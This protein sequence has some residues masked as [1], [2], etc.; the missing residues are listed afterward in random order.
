MTKR[1]MLFAISLI[2]VATTVSAKTLINSLPYTISTSDSYYLGA[3]LTSSGSGI[4][5][6]ANNVSIDF[7][8]YSI[9]G[10]ST[11][12]GVNLETSTNVELR[13]GTITNF[14]V[15]VSDNEGM[16]STRVINM[17]IVN[18]TGTGIALDWH[19]EVRDC[20]ISGNGS[21][22]NVWG[23]V[24]QGNIVSGNAS[25]AIAGS[26]STI[27]NNTVSLNS[28]LGISGNYSTVKN[29]AVT[30]NA[31]GGIQMSNALVDGN[32]AHSNS[33]FNLQCSSCALG[34]NMAP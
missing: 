22:I 3:N 21:G 23:C 25:Y 28:G 11:G 7:N 8:G 5:V 17:R 20:L 15:G 6:A 10:S 16:N 30:A 9:T 31:G 18:N 12:Y 29:N 33:G 19:C 34:T 24:V 27:I 1:F 2:F 26:N 32:T 4:I 13:N 14:G